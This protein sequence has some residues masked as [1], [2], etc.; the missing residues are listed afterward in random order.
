M[1]LVHRKHT[2][3]RRRNWNT[4]LDR[5][6]VPMLENPELKLVTLAMLPTYQSEV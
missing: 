4:E 1:A 3:E 5:V 6:V 2:L